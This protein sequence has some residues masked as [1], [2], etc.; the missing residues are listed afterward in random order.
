MS[1]RRGL[2]GYDRTHT[3]HKEELDSLLTLNIQTFKICEFVS[4]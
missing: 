4:I 1:P 2:N 3:T